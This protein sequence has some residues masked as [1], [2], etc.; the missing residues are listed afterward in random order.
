MDAGYPLVGLG[1]VRVMRR[2]LVAA[3]ALAVAALVAG[4]VLGYPVVG[5]GVVAGLA[6]GSLNGLGMRRM[7]GNA[8]ATEASK[9]AM[10]GASISRLG[11]ITAGVFILFL[12]DQRAGLGSLVG[13]A[14]FQMVILANSARILLR[15]LRREAGL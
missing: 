3:G 10:A 5:A 15:Q 6:L 7:V 13:L 12:V 14:L 9:R 1:V 8:V 4:V 11:L 2:T